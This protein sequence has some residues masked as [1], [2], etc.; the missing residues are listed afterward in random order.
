MSLW[1]LILLTRLFQQW[2]GHRGLLMFCLIN[3]LWILELDFECVMRAVSILVCIPIF[4]IIFYCAFSH[5]SWKLLSC[6]PHNWFYTHVPHDW[7]YSHALCFYVLLLLLTSYIEEASPLYFLN[8]NAV[9][10]FCLNWQVPFCGYLG[11]PL[12]TCIIFSLTNTDGRST[13][14]P[15]LPASSCQCWNMHQQKERRLK[16]AFSIPGSVLSH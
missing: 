9:H 7:V 4:T 14:Q 13:R 11:S 8:N 10:V 16:D 3:F 15:R 12:M 6:D 5:L 1:K 2:C